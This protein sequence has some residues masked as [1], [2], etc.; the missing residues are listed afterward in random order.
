[1][2]RFMTLTVAA[3]VANALCLIGVGAIGSPP[4]TGALTGQGASTTLKVEG[5]TCSSCAPIVASA[6]KKLDGV[7][8]ARVT[9]ETGLAE[10][11]YDPRK[12]DPAKLA[13]ALAKATGYKVTVARA[14]TA[15]TP[16]AAQRASPPM[17]VVRHS[18]LRDAFNASAG[19]TRLVTILSPMCPACQGGQGAVAR[20]FDQVTSDNLKGFV[21]W[22]PMKPG[23]NPE[24]AARQADVFADPRVQQ[25]WDATGAIGDTF[26]RTFGLKG[27]AWDIYAVDGPGIRWTGETPPKPTFWMHQLTEA[28]GADQALCL[29]PA[30]LLRAVQ[31]AVNGQPR[32]R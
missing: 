8:E 26:G 20:I 22:L 16:A 4:P 25:G 1:M 32:G 12:I 18:A 6:A 24:S 15:G 30:A 11:T 28:S 5:M 3:F 10:L 14:T 23:D 13:A 2:R 9:F 21:V 17:N 19:S 29:N 31:Q 7:S 27:R